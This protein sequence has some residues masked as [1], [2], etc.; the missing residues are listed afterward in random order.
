LKNNL[1]NSGHSFTAPYAALPTRSAEL[2]FL[3]RLGNF[4]NIDPAINYVMSECFRRAS[5]PLDSRLR[6][7]DGLDIEPPK[8]Y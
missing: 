6:G 2:F 5:I 7:N 8:Q 1:Y 4:K 3:Q